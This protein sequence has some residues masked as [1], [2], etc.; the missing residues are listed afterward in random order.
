MQLKSNLNHVFTSFSTKPPNN[1]RI[2]CGNKQMQSKYIPI[3]RYYHF[4]VHTAHSPLKSTATLAPAPTLPKPHYPLLCTIFLPYERSVGFASLRNSGRSTS[5]IH[6][7]PLSK[8]RC[9][10][11]KKFG[12]LPMGLPH[13]YPSLRTNPTNT[14]LSLA[15]HYIL[16]SLVKG[17]WI[18]TRLL[19]II[20]CNILRFYQR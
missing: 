3:L 17:S 13:H 18:A 6:A 14:A 2:F 16:G 8:V 12:R 10:R 5:G 1:Y 15:M 4:T 20:N 11:P 9:C 7:R 19:L